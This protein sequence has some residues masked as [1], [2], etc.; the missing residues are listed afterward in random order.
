MLNFSNFIYRN[1]G[2]NLARLIQTVKCKET[3]FSYCVLASSILC[4]AE[5]STGVIVSCIPTLGPVLFRDR[6][7][8]TKS[9]FPER[10]SKAKSGSRPPLRTSVSRI[11]SRDRTFDGTGFAKMSNDDVELVGAAKGMGY[12]ASVDRSLTS[13]HASHEAYPGEIIVSKGYAISQ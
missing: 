6:Q 2:I 5:M 13:T 9:T 3:D 10:S 1:A 8:Q 4:A 7:G 11:A 12:H